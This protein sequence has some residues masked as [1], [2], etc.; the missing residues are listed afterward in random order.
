VDRVLHEQHLEQPENQVQSKGK[1][2][3]KTPFYLKGICNAA[4]FIGKEL[5]GRLSRGEA[6]ELNM[7]Q[8]KQLKK[9]RWI[10]LYKGEK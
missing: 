4:P 9:Y 1:L 10:E 2:V 8:I 6:V 5:E 3:I 7:E